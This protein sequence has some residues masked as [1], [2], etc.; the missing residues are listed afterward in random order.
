MR[1]WWRW[2]GGWPCLMRDVA[3]PSGAARGTRA[4]GISCKPW[5]NRIG[6]RSSW[7]LSA[8]TRR[9]HS[10]HRHWRYEVG[11]Q[12]VTRELAMSEVPVGRP[13]LFGPEE[14]ITRGVRFGQYHLYQCGR[15]DDAYHFCQIRPSV[16]STLEYECGE[17]S[18]SVHQT[19]IVSEEK[20]QDGDRDLTDLLECASAKME[21]DHNVAEEEA[22]GLRNLNLRGVSSV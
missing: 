1:A 2:P 19:E 13:G 9:P 6:A 10:Q 5:R 18:K 20:D 15:V 7:T 12:G 4:C 22:A 8:W 16:V 14:L 11:I 21:T 3:P 17:P